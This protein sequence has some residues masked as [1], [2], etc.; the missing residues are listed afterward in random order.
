MKNIY[1]LATKEISRLT[2]NNLGTLIKLNGLQYQEVNE[3]Q[4]IYITSDE[5]IKEDDW[6]ILDMSHGSNPN[7]LHQMGKNK[8]SKTGGIN[9]SEPNS[10]TRS[11]KKII[12]TTHQNLIDD[13][14]QSIDNTFI[15]WLVKNQDCN[16][17][18][19]RNVDGICTTCYLDDV[20]CGCTHPTGSIFK[21][22]II[23]RP[24]NKIRKN[25]YCGNKVDFDEQC[26]HQCENCVDCTNVDYGFIDESRDRA[27]SLEEVA[28]KKYPDYVCESFDPYAKFFRSV[29]IEG[30]MFEREMNYSIKETENIAKEAWNAEKFE[31]NGEEVYH[32]VDFYDWFNKFR[33]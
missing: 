9:F 31:S 7:E 17:I 2:K 3:N 12:L 21:Y 11:C 22:E 6:F 14:I 26:G 30:V 25:F 28:F 33:K 29:F 18:E 19:V 5:E 24:K 13:G 1:L 8:W 23:Y 32:A 20:Y 16:F 27:L 15:R 4:Y 10:W